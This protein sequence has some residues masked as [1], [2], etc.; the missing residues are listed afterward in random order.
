ML[1]PRSLREPPGPFIGILPSAFDDL[2]PVLSGRAADGGVAVMECE[3]VELMGDSSSS[4]LLLGVPAMSPL[5]LGR[6]AS[7]LRA[8]KGGVL[9]HLKPSL[10]VEMKAFDAAKPGPE[11]PWLD[12]SAATT[13]LTSEEVCKRGSLAVQA[14]LS[15]LEV[16]RLT[17]NSRAIKLLE[18][19]SDAGAEGAA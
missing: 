16:A 10:L 6:R 2:A 12:S 3:G 7:E 11:Q 15:W 18:G 14:M 1:A 17:R 8:W 19:T 13:G 9:T 5:P 4:R